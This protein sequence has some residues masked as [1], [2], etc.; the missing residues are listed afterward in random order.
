MAGIAARRNDTRWSFRAK[1]AAIGACYCPLSGRAIFSWA[2]SSMR[3]CQINV[4]FHVLEPL[5]YARERGK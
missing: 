5:H 2:A 3:K 1:G 4:Q